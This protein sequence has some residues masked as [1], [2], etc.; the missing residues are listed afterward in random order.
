MSS[1][2][3][4]LADEKIV[5]KFVTVSKKENSPYFVS[6][7]CSSYEDCIQKTAEF[8][9]DI[10]LIQLKHP[11][12]KI[13][14][15]FHDLTLLKK[16]PILLIFHVIAEDQIVYSVTSHKDHGFVSGLKRFFADTLEGYQC[17]F[18]YIGEEKDKESNLIMDARINKLEK[19]EY[20][21]DILR[22]VTDSEFQYYKKKANLNL[23]NSGYYI[24]IWDFMEIEYADHDRNKNIYYFV[25]EEFIKECQSILDAYDGGEVFYINPMLL[26][27]IINDINTLSYASK[28]Q[29]LAELVSSLN[30][31]TNSKTAF[32]YMSGYIRNFESLRAAY[33][34]FHFI[35]TYS[36]F[37]KESRLLTQAYVDSVKKEADICQMHEMIQEIKEYIN[38]DIFHEKLTQL[39]ERLFLTIVKPSLNMNLYYY[40]HTSISSALMD[41][42][43]ILFHKRLPSNPPPSSLLFS[44]I[45]QS[46]FELIQSINQ[47]K[48]EL[49]NRYVVK[50]AIVLQAIEYIHQHYSEDITV[51]HIAAHLNISNS[52]LSQIFKKELGISMIGYLI[53]Y[54]IQK[55]EE[56]LSGSMEPI[57]RIASKVGFCEVKHF[58]K[59]FKKLTGFTPMQY[60][61]QNAK[62][63]YI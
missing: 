17:S 53:S 62:S 58:S 44:S 22:G 6:A 54:R 60:K 37:C 56:L 12:Y 8:E 51:N 33:E 24:Y 43:N 16:S 41:K 20:L 2:L 36:F 13:H 35:K 26:C 5:S 3:V 9:A 50:S 39:I 15:F 31:V 63:Q 10:I 27:I 23:N 45:E 18:N 11:V 61:K 1:K 57:Y 59:T 52:Y 49:S 29:K 21:N 19:N 4:L 32:R 48:A 28:Q 7:I 40:C 30:S 42:Y 47:L 46:C 55:A 34:K 38:Y 14:N 25:G